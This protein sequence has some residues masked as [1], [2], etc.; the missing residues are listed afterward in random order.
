MR[1]SSGGKSLGSAILSLLV[2]ADQRCP[3]IIGQAHLLYHGR[4]RTNPEETAQTFAQLKRDADDLYKA[5]AAV[6]A[7]INANDRDMPLRVY[8]KRPNNSPH[9]PHEDDC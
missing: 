7:A 1:D 8:R 3:A 6:Q 4:L 2:A 9:L 5:I